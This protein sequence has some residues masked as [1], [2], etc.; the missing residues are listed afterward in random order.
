MLSQTAQQLAQHIHIAVVEFTDIFVAVFRTVACERLCRSQLVQVNAV[1]AVGFDAEFRSV[2]QVIPPECVG[3]AVHREMLR[4][5]GLAV[6]L[7]LFVADGHFFAHGLVE[8]RLHVKNPRVDVQ[9]GKPAV[10][11]HVF[12]P[13]P[14]FH[15]AS[16][17]HVRIIFRVERVEARTVPACQKHVAHAPGRALFVHLR[18]ITERMLDIACA[19]EIVALVERAF[20]RQKRRIVV[21][22]QIGRDI[23]AVKLRAVM[24]VFRGDGQNIFPCFIAFPG[25]DAV[26]LAKAKGHPRIFG[27][28]ACFGYDARHGEARVMAADVQAVFGVVIVH[29]AHGRKAAVVDLA[30]VDVPERNAAGAP[31]IFFI[32][33]IAH[34]RVARAL[35]RVMRVD[36]GVIGVVLAQIDAAD[37]RHQYLHNIRR[38][39]VLHPGTDAQTV[40]F[41][42]TAHS[43][44]NGQT[45]ELRIGYLQKACSCTH[46]RYAGQQLFLFSVRQRVQ[47]HQRAAGRGFDII[48]P[49][50]K[51][52]KADEIVCLRRKPGA[53][54]VCF[55]FHDRPL[56]NRIFHNFPTPRR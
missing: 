12:Q 44:T 4:P 10:L 13:A 1:T 46:P 2:Q 19:L 45:A 48:V 37:V 43:H 56:K 5:V 16:Q 28:S 32:H 9:R 50:R 17:L 31:E 27:A 42:R 3:R 39:V 38:T 55:Q 6:R 49:C 15:R 54:S 22:I 29:P 52:Y 53:E 25:T 20:V 21:E 23:R 33:T 51:V 30:A 26:M 11:P 35:A 36:D 18:D 34:Y 24:P 40:V 14:E 8:I 41:R 7:A 47:L